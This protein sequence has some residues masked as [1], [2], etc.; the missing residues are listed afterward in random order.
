MG[1]SLGAVWSADI[2][3][4]S[5]RSPLQLSAEEILFRNGFALRAQAD[6][7]SALRCHDC[8]ALMSSSST[9]S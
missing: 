2:L 5:G 6:R 8:I 7:M 3:S 4:A 9:R 1:S